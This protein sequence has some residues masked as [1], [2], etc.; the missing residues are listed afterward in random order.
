MG[1]MMVNHWGGC[2]DNW[3]SESVSLMVYYLAY[4]LA[5]QMILLMDQMMVLHFNSYGGERGDFDGIFFVHTSVLKKV[6]ACT[7]P[8]AEITVPV[9]GYKSTSGLFQVCT[10]LV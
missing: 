8:Y 2:L 3:A 6:R 1:C 4:H 10:H 7:F 5:L 9:L